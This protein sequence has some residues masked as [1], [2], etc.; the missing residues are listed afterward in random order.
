MACKF[1]LPGWEGALAVL[2]AI[3]LVLLLPFL[4]W[5]HSTT[6]IQTC[7]L[8]TRLHAELQ[9]K[10]RNKDITRYSMALKS[11]PRYLGRYLVG[12]WRC[13]LLVVTRV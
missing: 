5:S 12:N 10:A 13:R 8:R 4:E 2:R 3:T 1:D 11:L 6:S 7:R 9:P